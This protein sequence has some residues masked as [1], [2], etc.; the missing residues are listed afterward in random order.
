ASQMRQGSLTSLYRTSNAMILG[1]RLAEKIGARV[2]SNITVQTSAGARLN[3]QVVGMSHT[4][5]RTV[6]EATA[7]VLLKTGQ[8]IEQQTGLVN[9][10]RSRVR[11]E[12]H[13]SELQSHLNL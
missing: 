11:S 12:E 13:T 10:I 2:G 1:D 3:A 6:D 7:Y 4:G 9:E 5:I 8:I